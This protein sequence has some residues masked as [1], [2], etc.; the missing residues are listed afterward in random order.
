[1]LVPA[2]VVIEFLIVAYLYRIKG[3]KFQIIADTESQFVFETNLGRFRLDREKKAV[4]LPGGDGTVTTIPFTEIKKLDFGLARE[5]AFGAELWFGL[6]FTDLL[7]QYQDTNEWYGVALVL[8]S[9]K[10]VPI[11]AAGQLVRREF[12]ME[13][14]LQIQRA[15]LARFG[16]YRDVGETSRA[17]LEEILR[18]F[19]QLGNPLRLV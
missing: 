13:W 10:R 4:V 3:A 5:W 1:M 12:L 15:L 6:G 8:H 2:V 9:G 17:V 18:G 14:W 7:K 19:K 11:Y 16:L